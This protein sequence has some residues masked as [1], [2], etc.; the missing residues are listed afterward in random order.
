MPTDL[1]LLETTVREAGAIARKYFGGS[2]KTWNKAGQPVTDADIEVNAFLHTHLRSARPNFG[3]LS[4]ETEDV[5]AQRASECT[6]IV[7]PIDGT[8]AFVKGRPH[9]S[10]SVAVVRDGQPTSG[11]VFNPITEECFTAARGEGATLNGTPIH[12]SDRV[13]VEGCRMLGAKD[14]FAHP[15]WNAPPNRPWPPMHIE[16]RS[17]IA[18]RMA[19]VAS[20]AFDAALFLS[21]KHDWDVAA[22][23]LIVREAGGVVTHHDGTPP[24]YNG[25]ETLQPSMVCAGPNLHPLLLERLQHLK[26]PRR[27]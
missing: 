1:H 27:G 3:W 26:L 23:D 6:F 25:K 16:T 2:Y 14:V 18:Y 17:S 4:E 22:G 13:Q 24:R 9:F 19:L 10:I 12:A 20:G 11:I 21:A 15:A 8:T 7:D 5:P